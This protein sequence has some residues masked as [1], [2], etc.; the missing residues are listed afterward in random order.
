MA[1]SFTC[2]P[3]LAAVYCLLSGQVYFFLW[4]SGSAIKDETRGRS[5]K[6]L[7][8]STFSYLLTTSNRHVNLGWVGYGGVRSVATE[9]WWQ[10]TYI[11]ITKRGQ[12]KVTPHLVATVFVSAIDLQID[13]RKRLRASDV[14]ASAVENVWT[15]THLQER[16][17][18]WTFVWLGVSC[19]IF[20]VCL[21]FYW[22][23]GV[24]VGRWCLRICTAEPG[25][26]L[27][28][29]RR[30]TNQTILFTWTENVLTP[31]THPTYC[32]WSRAKG[33][34]CQ[35]EMTPMIWGPWWKGRRVARRPRKGE[36]DLRRGPGEHC[37]RKRMLAILLPLWHLLRTVCSTDAHGSADCNAA[38]HARHDG[39]P[40][41]A[42]TTGGQREGGEERSGMTVE[43][44]DE[45]AWTRRGPGGPTQ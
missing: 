24:V 3:I 32:D 1:S 15:K 30:G 7:L 10:P 8:Y 19:L 43:G 44:R 27:A 45:A 5:M 26:W 25:V 6:S 41:A 20:V 23:F 17:L 28:V 9:S 40:L 37:R 42:T 36:R 39:S 18:F 38:G 21:C 22:S 12:K 4:S 33:N 35:I 13:H 34:R 29:A 31:R 11:S 14:I 2:Y 16:H